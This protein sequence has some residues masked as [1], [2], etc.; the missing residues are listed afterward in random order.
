MIE[1]VRTDAE[2]PWHVRLVG[3]NGQTVAHGENLA[4][5]RDAD[6]AIAAIA[7]LFGITMARPP[8][9]D[10]DNP[11]WLMGEA[12]DGRTYA[13][14]VTHVDERDPDAGDDEPADEDVEP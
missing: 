5:E 14:P 11:T 8:E 1:I 4:D 13:Y 9:H 6:N 2:Q 10:V 3:S 12:P 7:E